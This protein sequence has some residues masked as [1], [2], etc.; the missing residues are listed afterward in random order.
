[1]VTFVI[2]KQKV[3]V[4]TQWAEVTLKQAIE[5]SAN[6][7]GDV[8]MTL[9]ILTGL[10]YDVC[11]R[12]RTGDVEAMFTPILTWLGEDLNEQ[13]LFKADPPKEFTLGIDRYSLKNFKPGEMIYAQH[14]NLERVINN[15]DSRDIDKVAPCIAICVQNP[16]KYSEGRQVALEQFVQQMPLFEAFSIA[17]FF[18]H[19]FQTSSNKRSSAIR[20]IQ[21]NK[22]EPEY[23]TLKSSEP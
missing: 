1:M 21:A 2:Q 5:L 22:S 14:L 7:S 8:I 12:F 18:F 17:G 9:S 4:P 6:K 19:K 23:M 3:Q 11:Y 20:I 15:K 16:E 10:P 13:E